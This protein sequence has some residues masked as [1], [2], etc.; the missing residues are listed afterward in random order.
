MGSDRARSSGADMPA[1]EFREAAARVAAWSSDYLDTVGDLPVL[2][3]VMPGDIAA[4]LPADAPEDPSSVDQILAD[5]EDVIIPGITHWNHPGFFAY[6]GITGSGPGILGEML[7]ATLNV[8]AML[9]RTSPSATELEERSLDW[10]RQMIGLPAG[11]TGHI[12]DT[13]SLSSLVAIAAAREVACPRVRDE[14]LGGR[15]LP[16]LRL[17]CSEEAHSSIEKAGVTLGIGRAGT[18]R[19]ATDDEFRMDPIALRAAIEDDIAAGIQPFCVVATVGT[20]STTSIDPVPVIADI[21]E[22]FQLWLHVDAAYGGAAA[23]VPEMRGVLAG[24]DRADSLVVNP[25]KWLFVPIDCSALY[26]RKP[27]VVRQA[28]SIVP[29]YLTT[30]EGESVTNLMDYGPALGRRFRALKLWM[31]L[32]YFGR[33]GLADRIGEHIRLARLFAEWVDAAPDWEVMAPIPFSTVCFRY[34]PEGLSPEEVDDRNDAILK[35][36]NAS[37]E[38]FLSHTRLNGRMVLRLAVGNLRTTEE[39]VRRAWELLNN[40]CGSARVRECGTA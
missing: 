15:D 34:A 12:Q 25:H 1:E 7:A 27:E 14:G 10:L 22:E 39:H 20:T 18:R 16:R 4:Q 29:E 35:A 37:G 40:E 3:R 2:A 17:Y 11:F 13:A 32:R 28:F 30:P 26:L 5:F 6:F 23:V 21:C 8:N 38:V 33:S 36:V 24:C 31:V 19:I 9:W